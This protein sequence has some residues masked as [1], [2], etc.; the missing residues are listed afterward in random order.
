MKN[1][2]QEQL[3][4]AGLV[5][6]N[7]LR[8]A[9]TQKNKQVKQ[10][11]HN[12]TL[13]AD[14]VKEQAQQARMEQAA[15]DR[16]LNEQRKQEE[17]RKQISAQIKQL[18]EHN[19][20]P[21]DKSIADQFDDSLAYHFTDNN[22]V[23]ALYVSKIMREQIA[24]GRLAIVKLGQHYEVVPAETA[25]KIKARD[26]SVIIVFIEPNQSI[27]KNDDPY[28]AYQIPDDLMW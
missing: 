18:I 22:K 2:L 16:E 15:K 14:E 19:R 1:Q 4:K 5:N 23:K 21:Q 11:Q 9:K 7:Q 26:E 6:A 10:Q 27:E 20:L 3:L 17:A 12:K 8:T 28:A 13:S 24:E 25:Q